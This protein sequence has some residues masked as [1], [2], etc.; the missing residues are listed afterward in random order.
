M[1]Y[2]GFRTVEEMVGRVDRLK[3]VPNAKKKKSSKVSLDA[4]LVA[5]HIQQG[6]PLHFEKKGERP[7]ISRFD[8]AIEKRMKTFWQEPKPMTFNLQVN[9]TDRAIGSAL[10]G[11]ITKEFGPKG[12]DEGTLTFNLSGSAGQSFGAFLAPGIRLTLKGEVNDYLGKGMSGGEIVVIPPDDSKIRPERNII[13]GNVVM[14]GATGGKTFINGMA[15]ERFCVRNSGAIAVVEGI[16]DHGCEYMTGGTV[17]VLG[18]MGKNFAAG[19]SGGI[20]YVYD[21]S[22]IF[23]S[24]CNLDM[25][26]LEGVWDVKDQKVLKDLIEEHYSHTKSH[27]A[28]YILENWEVQYPQFVKV[29]PIEYRKGLERMQL[30][31]NRDDETMSVT[32]EVYRA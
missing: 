4:I 5:D 3:Y 16:G 9:N 28:Q 24:R 29:V 15:G 30:N 26:E 20:A 6:V 8:K 13:C 19:M 32:E 7:G 1:A 11:K 27:L 23:D 21:P 14:Y 17:V 18:E 25:V 2:L 22:E 10:S 31:E 12:L